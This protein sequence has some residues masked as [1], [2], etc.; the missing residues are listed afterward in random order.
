MPK[1]PVRKDVLPYNKYEHLK[2]TDLI[3]RLYISNQHR[4]NK[5]KYYCFWD[6][7]VVGVA[8]TYLI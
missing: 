2:I 8:G 6:R 1:L 7:V 5:I 3:I 4:N